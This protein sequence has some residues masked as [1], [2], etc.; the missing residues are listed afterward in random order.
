MEKGHHHQ[1]LPYGQIVF[2]C[3]I[4]GS[5]GLFVQKLHQPPQVIVFFRFLFGFI[6]LLAGICVTKQGRALKIPGQWKPLVL[7]GAINAASWLLVTKSIQL[8]GVANGFIL[9]YTA[10]CFVV[11]LAPVLVK[12]K[13]TKRSMTALI[14]CFLGIL[15]VVGFGKWD[16]AG[17]NWQG[18]LMGLG[19][20]L[21]YA[22]YIILLKRLPGHLLG[23]V[24]NTYVC[25]VISVLTFPLAAP[26]LRAISPRELLILALAG[27]AIQGVAT[28]SYMFG[29]R[30]V[31]AQHA[32][33]LC[34][35]EVLFASIFAALFLKEGFTIY[36]LVGGLLIIGGGL[37]IVFSA[38]NQNKEEQHQ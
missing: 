37:L 7:A 26:A 8:T 11:L 35:L 16:P 3:L 23:L 21:F 9:Y 36:L 20:G 38:R 4:W 27:I 22:L 1:Y 18:N 13:I 33:I 17:L 15:N 10:P 12:E 24:S 28:S 2:A 30:K 6:I 19:S 31:S 34:Y 29:L 5:Y 25:A 14:L 32:S